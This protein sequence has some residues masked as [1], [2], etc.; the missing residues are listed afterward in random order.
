[1]PGELINYVLQGKHGASAGT[2]DFIRKLVK[3][4]SL[5][6]GLIL[7]AGNSIWNG[8]T[9][10][11]PRTEKYLQCK[12]VPM[13]VTQVYAGYLANQIGN[14]DYISSDS[15]SCVSGHSAWY[16]ASNLLQ[17]GRLDAVVVVAADN[18]LA[19]EYL[20][21]F[22]DQGLSKLA[23]EEDDPNIKKMH[24][25]HGCN[26][27]VFES[28]ACNKITNNN[29][30]ATVKDM[31]IASEQHT[32]SLGISSEGIGYNK[33]M[34]RVNTDN[35]DFIKTHSTFSENNQIEEVLIN[36]KFGDIKL[37][38]YKLRLGHTMGAST[39]IETALAIQE[40]SGTFLSLGAG[41]GNVFSSAVVEIA[42]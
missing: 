28:E 41:M 35:I 10:I 34:D 37:V 23:T 18:G 2:F 21:V 11:M 9:S 12:V 4:P 29:T 22:G 25:G 42:K 5:K 16:T 38:N 8:Y 40:E 27:S 1:M 14:F 17:L 6:V 19:E 13:L 7:A 3:T 39:A 32:S 31:H 36:R 24:L 20:Y 33:V 30:I 15:V 26:I